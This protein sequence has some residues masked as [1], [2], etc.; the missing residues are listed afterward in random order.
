LAKQAEKKGPATINGR[1]WTAAQLTAAADRT[2]AE[3]EDRVK[4][5]AIKQTTGP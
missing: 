5:F 4:K 3:M 1:R 2:Y